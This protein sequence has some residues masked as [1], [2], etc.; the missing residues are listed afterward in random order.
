VII[1]RTTVMRDNKNFVND[2]ANDTFCITFV[3]TV[4]VLH[5]VRSAGGSFFLYRYGK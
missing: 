1:I 5:T 4:P 2:V 3:P